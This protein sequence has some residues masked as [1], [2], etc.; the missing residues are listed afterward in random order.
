MP[1][2]TL[3]I[4]VYEP[5][6][7]PIV[8]AGPGGDSNH[9]DHTSERARLKAYSAPRYAVVG[10]GALV[11]VLIHA[12]VITAFTR[13]GG[14]APPVHHRPDDI[15]MELVSIDDEGSAPTASTFSEHIQDAALSAVTVDAATEDVSLPPTMWADPAPSDVMEDSE[16][17]SSLFGRYVGQ[18]DARIQRAWSKPRAAPKV[19]IFTCRVRIEQDSRGAVMEIALER[20][21]GDAAWQLSLVQAIQLASPLPAPP[22]PKV[23]THILRM[24]FRGEPVSSVP[25]ADDHGL[26]PS[27]NKVAQVS[28]PPRRP[29]RITS[30]K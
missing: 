27:P 20:C 12:V 19:G 28:L 15:S 23:F 6:V 14:Q 13:N 16:P 5:P 10:V 7:A 22:D 11:S 2:G 17:R 25:T 26:S 3:E 18:I 1:R 21:N 8:R 9:D 4:G 24:E 29:K 30:A